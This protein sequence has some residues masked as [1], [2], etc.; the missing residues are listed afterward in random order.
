MKKNFLHALASSVFLLTIASQSSYAQVVQGYNERIEQQELEIR[1]LTGELETLKYKNQNLEVKLNGLRK[2]M[3]FRFKDIEQQSMQ[4][5]ASKTSLANNT[6]STYKDNTAGKTL[7]PATEKNFGA[8][9]VLYDAARADM[10]RKNYPSASF[11][12]QKMI[13]DYPSHSLAPNAYYWLGETYY[14]QKQYDKAALTFLEGKQKF[15]K[16]SKA[17]HSLLK[18]GLSLTYLKQKQD[19]CLTF[20]EVERHYLPQ[21]NSLLPTLKSS[22]QKAGCV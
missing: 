3:E 1:R 15:P 10:Q 8:A 2:E 11:G 13:K 7:S 18:L 21:D 17:G 20:D 9:T 19:A 16:S 4:G 12:F 6:T 14:A 5:N 22:R